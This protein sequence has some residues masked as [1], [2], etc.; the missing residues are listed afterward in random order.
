MEAPPQLAYWAHTTIISIALSVRECTPMKMTTFASYLFFLLITAL[1]TVQYTSF[2]VISRW[3]GRVFLSTKKWIE[4]LVSLFFKEKPDPHACV[5]LFNL[6]DVRETSLGGKN[7]ALKSFLTHCWKKICESWNFKWIFVDRVEG[8]SSI[9]EL[10]TIYDF[11]STPSTH[12]YW[13]FDWCRFFSISAG[14]DRFTE[15]TFLCCRPFRMLFFWNFLV[16]VNIIGSH[17]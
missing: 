10:L 5:I 12:I 1:Y 11:H 14:P 6:M 16:T 9:I 2:N 17:I 15:P 13:N 8:K 4:N 3:P 7:Y